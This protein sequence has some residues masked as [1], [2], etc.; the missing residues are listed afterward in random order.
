MLEE[1]GVPIDNPSPQAAPMSM[2]TIFPETAVVSDP[3]Y[4]SVG[5]TDTTRKPVVFDTTAPP[6]STHD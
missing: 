5:G 6:D 2:D 1:H 4:K 3:T